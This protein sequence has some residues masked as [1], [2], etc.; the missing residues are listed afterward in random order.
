MQKTIYLLSLLCFLATSLTAQ[1][2]DIPA[3]QLAELKK[4]KSYQT[5]SA[6]GKSINIDG[7]LDDSIWESV[8][9]GTDFIQ[10]S[11][12]EG[13]PPTQE[14][15]FKILYDEKFL[16]VGFRCYDDEPEKIVQRMSRRDGFQGD[17]VE[18][19]IDSYND[20]RTAFSF[21]IS[22][23]GVKGDEF[24][25]NNGQN[26]DSSWNPIWFAA[27]AVD[28]QGWTAE[29]K[30]PL[31]QIRYGQK[32]IHTWGIQFTRRDFRAGARNIWQYIPRTSGNWV[33]EFGKL[34]GLKGI[35]PQKQIEI[36]PYV[37]AKTESFQKEEGNPFATG[38]SN[39][40][41]A[42]LD[43]KI[44]VTG[45]LTLDFTVN[46][47]FGQVEADPAAINLDG[48][49]IFFS[50]RRPFFIE[51][52]NLF[53]YQVTNAEAG[54]SFTSDNAFYSRRIGRSPHHYPDLADGEYADVPVNTTIL[55]AAKFSGKTKQGTG[56]AILESVTAREFA[57]IKGGNGDREEEV[58]PLTNYFVSRVTQDFNEGR[59]V[60]GGIL[61]STQ[62]DIRTLEL[63]YLHKNAFSG[64]LDFL[65]FW[66][67]RTY[68]IQANALVSRV[69]GS[70]NAILNTQTA[71]EHYFQ[72][73]DA[74][75]LSIDS[76]ATSLTGTSGT[77]NIGKY[78]GNLIFQ[79]GFTWRS[80]QLEL[81]DIGF[82]RNTDEINHYFWAGYRINEPFSI[83][84]RL[85]FN[86]NHWY[87]WDFGGD[88]LYQAWNTN[89]HTTFKNQWAGGFGVTYEGRDISNTDLRGGP[90]LR[91]SNGLAL[92]GYFY[93]DQ[94][95]KA[96]LNVNGSIG[97]GFEKGHPNTVDSRN[98]SV[99][100]TFQPT[101][102]LNLSVQPGYNIYKRQ[103]QFVD[104]ID[105]GKSRKYIVSG[106][107]QHTLSTTI[108]L[109]Y[110]ITPN[111]T[112]QYYGQPFISRG[113]Y[114][115][116]KFVGNSMAKEFDERFISFADNQISYVDGEYQIDDDVD[117]AVDYT[118]G[119]PDFNFMQWR[120]NMV[121]R[122]E[123]VPG[124]ELF[125][126]WTQGSNA[127]GNPEDNLIPSL[128]ENIFS[129]KAHNI[130]L[131]K[132]TYRFLL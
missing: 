115:D 17:W 59:T 106:L 22:A 129:Q 18:I 112:I 8:D 99:G 83:F 104:N 51:N 21:T 118:F 132:W 12:E 71:F 131:L 25:S 10:I 122:W 4:Q 95:K 94:R 77:V 6:S 130:F 13:E 27:T 72:R 123:Y 46:P 48:F 53:D 88:N 128:R 93:S 33:S 60:V 49:R 80:P 76:T 114:Q 36:Q 117:Q 102:A 90:A 107:E 126:V 81:N 101:N 56:I 74:D 121:V 54:G 68:F 87:R 29:I 116:F 111:L 20:K 108:R 63:D 109:N 73:P 39:G 15:A 92:W 44:G 82:L 35:K 103:A 105:L 64:G 37:V 43:G 66:K 42:G 38:T 69:S 40:L 124:S 110:N 100:V 3:A 32:D 70:E 5:H 127:S 91:R 45:D 119:D 50:E 11:P 28:D 65:H 34:E 97:K 89:M 52:R 1:N 23:S 125:L 24:I 31:S 57:T 41:N 14:T 96:Y 19:N 58:E 78:T 62:R 84:N 120:S 79:G 47:D 2:A 26:W 61:T 113:R 9:W 67:D 86:V 75:Y 55:G 7:L 98:I 85:A 30:I 16:Y